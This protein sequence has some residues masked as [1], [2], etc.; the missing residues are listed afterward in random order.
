VNA[1]KKKRRKPARLRALDWAWTER[2]THE[3]GFH[4]RGRKVDEY[5]RAD[6]LPGVGYSWCMS[7]VQ[8]CFRAAGRPLP[9][10]TASV[11]FFLGWARK[12][13]WVVQKPARGDLVCFNFDADNWP[14]HV[15]FVV[16]VYPLFIL[17]VEGNTSPGQRG[18]QA[19]GG[20][21]YSRYRRK[22]S[23]YAYVRVPDKA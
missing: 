7:F 8:W 23:R 22:S 16:H 21:V 12:A 10:L 19:D 2:G 9:H 1:P 6:D 11:G 20:G 17:T 4:N 15:G 18:S 3:V 14:D 13:G 5:Q